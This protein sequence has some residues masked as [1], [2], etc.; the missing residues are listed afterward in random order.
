MPFDKVFAKFKARRLHSGGPEGPTVTNPR[1]ARAIFMS[2]RAKA[3]AGDPEYQAS[4]PQA[5][6]RPV[7]PGPPRHPADRLKRRQV[8]RGA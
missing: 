7:A 5:A 1:Q 4:A 2:E 3:Q 8:M 6:P